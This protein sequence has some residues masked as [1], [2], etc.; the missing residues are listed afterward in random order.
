MEVDRPYIEKVRNQ[1]HKKGTGLELAG[2]KIKREAKGNVEKSKRARRLQEWK[3]MDM[4][5]ES[6][7]GSKRMEGVCEW[8]LPGPQVRKAMMTMMNQHKED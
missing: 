1:H 5:Q 3:I 7:P 2:K 4:H 6:G 8:S